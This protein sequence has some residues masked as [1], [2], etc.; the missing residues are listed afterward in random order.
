MDARNR[1]VN[2]SGFRAHQRVFGSSLRLP[3]CLASDDY[4]DRM[5]V[6]TDPTTEFH[7]AA[8][9]R[10]AAQKA[11]FKNKDQEAIRQAAAARSRVQP[12]FDV[13]EGDVVYVWRNNIRANIKGWVGP[14]VTVCLDPTRTSAW[15]S[16]RGAVIKTSM[17]RIRPATDSEWLGAE[18]IK[19][20]TRD[21]KQH[22]AKNQQRGYIDASY[23]VGSVR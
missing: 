20:L 12:K 16:M 21:T 9:I 2:R 22:L 3:G 15:I 19:L 23:E 10:D 14:G 7:R 18:L 8:K 5:A 13:R 11:L 17:D 1:Y 4:V 6:A